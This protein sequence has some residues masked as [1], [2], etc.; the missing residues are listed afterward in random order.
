MTPMPSWSPA[1]TMPASASAS[2]S[3]ATWWRCVCRDL[4]L[5]RP[6]A[7]DYFAGR[8]RPLT[9]EDIARHECIRFRRPDF[10]DVYRWEFERDGQAL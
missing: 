8:G 4:Q 5:D 9:P 3:T 10:G 2:I 1:A 6:G 7:P